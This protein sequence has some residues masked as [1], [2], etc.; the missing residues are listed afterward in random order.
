[1]V[2]RHHY[3]FLSAIILVFISLTGA[4]Q[5]ASIT[6][7]VDRPEVYEGESLRFTLEVRGSVD[8][9]PDFS[10]LQKDFD[11]LGRNKSSSMQFIN[12]RMSSK[13]QWILDLMPKHKG[14]IRIPP[15]SFG[16]DQSNEVNITVKPAQVSKGGS[17]AE[18]IFLQVSADP[19]QSYVQAQI[20]YKVQIYVAVNINNASL[21]EPTLSD[22]DAVIEKLGDDKH[23]DTM[24]MGRHY[25]V[26][27]RR[28]AIFPQQSG[29]L[30]IDPVVFSAQLVVNSSFSP[31]FMNPFSQVG[32][33][34]RLQSRPIE[35]NIKSMPAG[36]H[37]KTWLP[38]HS[39]ALAEQ[40]PADPPKFK[41]G[42]AVT[43]T[44]TLRTTG[45]TA[46]QLPEIASATVQGFKTYPD[47][48]Q[49][50]DHKTDSGI[51]G[52]RQ[53]KIA[54]IATKPGHYVLPAININ[55]WNTQT[56]KAQT[57]QIPA[58]TIEV[59][60]APATETP[61]T[62]PVQQKSAPQTAPKPNSTP[63]EVKTPVSVGKQAPAAGIWPW[64]SLG[65][66]IG[67]LAT[68][69]FMWYRSRHNKPQAENRVADTIKQR[70]LSLKET[71]KKIKQ[72]CLANDAA[73]V[74]Q[75]L[76]AWS[77]VRFP[78]HELNS[79]GELGKQLGGDA[80][81]YIT[82]LNKALYSRSN[83]AWQGLPLWEALQHFQAKQA[84]TKPAQ[85]PALA[86]LYP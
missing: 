69:L 15:I 44:L 79:L 78:D 31:F 30:R 42:E 66:A 70:Q 4:A 41:V 74:K 81:S 39:L 59:I 60:G 65:L 22:A 19:E 82:E 26:I 32:K 55:W 11:V 8:G 18:D 77:Q 16:N 33:T 76:L 46:A 21:S 13:V 56:H 58:R 51:T 84:A 23:F 34:K 61:A 83:Q 40:W 45:L 57:A 50:K 43:R 1:M 14:D 36:Q 17:S 48:P 5:A 47:Q 62:P 7:T 49:L 28:Y 27:E 72:A 29:K 71:E 6:A 24:H 9:R 20:I 35:I 10:P 54:M 52:Q 67:W 25:Q 38:A 80:E 2:N 3:S 63:I 37:A 12:G 86:S 68:L 64:V 85:S 73:A 75:A 53:E